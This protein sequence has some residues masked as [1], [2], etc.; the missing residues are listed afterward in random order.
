MKVKNVLPRVDRTARK[1]DLLAVWA[2]RKPC[3]RNCPALG[4]F[5]NAV[6]PYDRPSAAPPETGSITPRSIQSKPGRG[7]KSQ[8]TLYV[9]EQD[10]H[11]WMFTY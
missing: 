1:I 10:P 7:T 9:P 4:R 5:A 6:R 2:A 8:D 3:R 11:A